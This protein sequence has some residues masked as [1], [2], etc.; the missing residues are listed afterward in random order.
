MLSKEGLKKKFSK[1]WK[2]Q[3]QVELFKERGFVRKTCK[4]GNNFWTLDPDRKTCPNPP[5]QNYEFIGKPI[6][7]ER[8][9]YIETWRAFEKFFV[10]NGH[11]S[12]PR[13]PVV[14]RW[15]PDLFFTIASIQDFQRI[16][17]GNIV[18]EYPADPLIVPQ[19][20][21]RFPDI[22]NV[23][24]T[25]RHHTSFIM[26]GQHSFGKYW[27]DRTIELNFRFLHDV[28]GIP[29]K[30]IVYI[31]DMWTMPDFSQF[32]PSLETFSRGLELVNSVFS[33][34]TASGSTY[35]ELPTK[36]IDV[37]W[38]HERL[39]W[40]SNGTP[41]GYDCAFGPVMDWMKKQSGLHKDTLFEKYSRFAGSMTFDE[42]ED[43]GP[44]RQ[45]IAKTL[46][47]G[48]KELNSVVEPMQALYA[49]A[50]HSK[51]LLFAA[52]DG[53]IPSNVGGGYNLRVILR[54][55]LSFIQEFGFS[56][57][58]M[59]IA[60]LHAGFLEPMFPEL[61]D[62]LGPLEKI[63]HVEKE[64]YNNTMSRAGVLI[65]R[66]LK[67]GIDTPT[68][69]K[70]YT[71]NG[72]S[73]ELVDK[74]ANKEGKDFHIPEDFYAK[75]TEQHMTGSKEFEKDELKFDVTK[76]PETEM[77]YYEKPNETE[78]TAK[79]IKRMGDWVVLDRTLFYPMGG[80]QPSDIG[81]I[82]VKG[83]KFDVV[84]VQKIGNVVL[85]KVSGP[86][87]GDT[88][89]GRIDRK[90]RFRLMQMHTSTH[91]VAGAARKVLGRHVWQ[92]GA[93]KDIDASRIDLTHYK[94]FTP[95]ELEAI[96][97]LANQS[98][99]QAIPVE[100]RFIPRSEA[101]QKYGFVLYQ[102]GASPGKTVRVVRI[103]DLDVEACGGM[104]LSNTKDAEK[105]KIIK[106][107]RTQDGVN[108]I[109]FTCGV[110]AEKFT[111]GLE[112]LFR[113]T[114]NLMSKFPVTPPKPRFDQRDLKDAANVFSIEPKL[115]PATMEKFAREI[116][117]NNEALNYVRK[118]LGLPEKP[119]KER[120][121]KVSRSKTMAEACELIF[122]LW[123]R[124]RKEA[125]KMREKMSENRA[126]GLLKKAR[127]NLVFDI[128]KGARKELIETASKL[129]SMNPKLTV[130][131][132]NEGGEIVGMSKTEDISRKIKDICQR[133]GGSGGGSRTLAQG[134]AELSKLRRL[135]SEFS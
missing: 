85:H 7:K 1:D 69:I 122:G 79:V 53:G 87:E 47:V 95:E 28:L 58:L 4:C 100:A 121:E 112:G 131:L 40:F 82:S 46:G 21:L 129:I 50:D 64:R 132:A 133:A 48:V 81:T 6:T 117:I 113:K 98:I 88:V 80:G 11:E 55:A 65:S 99:R 39:V 86:K 12:V 127:G 32:G 106:T 67:I 23:G 14:D 76:L 78:F 29:E 109:V 103:G 5:C 8:L 54:R 111:E 89:S 96:E 134:K 114:L 123:K 110:S 45:R 22:P 35:K 75:L 101:E 33:Q 84:E 18:M 30:E 83:K 31:E 59:K 125:E 41:S 19:V 115:L 94:P 105:I 118:T 2:S 60:E 90:R 135:L 52:T 124:Q 126:E 62:G 49:I 102:G 36:V 26:P 93:K 71:S 77:M 17:Q 72:I 70:L 38:G 42:V 68:L 16:D 20:C 63:L 56:F 120:L 57:D 92:A 37:G 51:T 13:Y 25:G 34:Y 10:Q 73:P 24:V 130:I 97:K 9:N 43:V 74:V 91:I 27:K 15:R 66:H 3:Y 61:K 44:V 119:L 107:E 108:R 116:K 128:I 104:H